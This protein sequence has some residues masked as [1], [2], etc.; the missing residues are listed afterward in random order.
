[1]SEDCVVWEMQGQ[2]SKARLRSAMLKEIK[3]AVSLVLWHW[4]NLWPVSGR[5]LRM[6]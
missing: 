5:G 2:T 4:H 3:D 1:M 6:R